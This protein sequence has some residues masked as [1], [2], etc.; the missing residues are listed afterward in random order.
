MNDAPDDPVR[1]RD[2]H[3]QPNLVQR[4]AGQAARDLTESA[5]LSCTPMARIAVQLQA[6]QVQA[7]R[8]HEPLRLGWVVVAGAFLLG[9]ATA[10][11]A[12]HLDLLPRWLA[13]KGQDD[14]QPVSRRATLPA[15][16][17]RPVAGN[18]QPR[19]PVTE[20]PASREVAADRGAEPTARQATA[21][22]DG[23]AVP[24]TGLRRRL[25]GEPR[26]PPSVAML[27]A[28]P[29]TSSVATGRPA[30][31]PA[32]PASASVRPA[33]IFAPSP[34]AVPPP[35]ERGVPEQPIPPAPA[36]PEQRSPAAHATVAP[37]P[38]PVRT[39]AEAIRFLKEIVRALRIDHSPT[40]A[41]ALL[42]RHASE[43]TDNAFAEESLLLRVEAMLALGQRSAVLRLL[44]GISLTDVAAS[45]GLLL[46]RGELRAAAHRCA[47]GIGDFDLVLTDAGRPLRQALL[48]RAL[49]K[50]Q[51]GDTAG[52][53]ADFSRY[54]REFPGDPLP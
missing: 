47:E 46:T 24:P 21:R 49:C 32:W 51:L 1:L 27:G 41:L 33:E 52:A 43:L 42:D 13:P 18:N 48:G 7:A 9:I 25:L 54:R 4:I 29:G 50:R 31:L 39:G 14:P 2:Q 15:T 34:T 38:S 40:Q 11:S 17:A 26:K 23:R 16:K 35:A 10:A 36:D 45:R 12:A 30:P 5:Q 53:N 8:N 6:A 20:A 3:D 28:G 22:Q 44:D 19:L 37:Q